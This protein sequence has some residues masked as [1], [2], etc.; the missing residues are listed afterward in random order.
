MFEDGIG[1]RLSAV[2]GGNEPLEVLKISNELSAV[3]AFEPALREQALRLHEFRHEAFARVRGVERLD[4][5][6]STVVVISERVRG[7][8][9]SELLAVVEREGIPVELNAALCL[10]RQLVAAV[11]ALHEAAPDSCHGAIAPER[12]VITPEG[13]LVLVEYV[14][15]PALEE[16]HFSQE[17]YWKELGI[18]LP[19]TFGLP[20]F[21]L[22]ADVTQTGAV[23]LA[24]LLGRRLT[25]D[26]YPARISDVVDQACT[27]DDAGP[28]EPLPVLLR[29]WLRS[30]LQLEPRHSFVSGVGARKDLEVAL[31]QASPETERAAL[32][33]LITK[34]VAVVLAD[35]ANNPAATAAS[36]RPEQPA[37][38]VPLA[39]TLPV[40]S[41][42]ASTAPVELQQ[43]IPAETSAP[44]HLP[45]PPAAVQ[46]VR[47]PVPDAAVRVP[48]TTVPSKAVPSQAVPPTTVPPTAVPAVRPVATPAPGITAPSIP[49][50]TIPTLAEFHAVVRPPAAATSVTPVAHGRANDGATATPWNP[51]GVPATNTE[52][53]LAIEPLLAVPTPPRPVDPPIA[54]ASVPA[55]PRGLAV[56]P[57]T[58]SIVEGA[59]PAER[60]HRVEAPR[61][62][63]ETKERLA[64]GL[65][66]EGAPAK[67]RV[68]N[69]HATEG[70]PSTPWNPEGVPANNTVAP[71]PLWASP[72]VIA[73]A[74]VLVIATLGFTLLRSGRASSPAPTTGTLT[75]GTNPDGIAVFVDG[76][77]RGTTP[78]NVSL[79]AGDHVLELVTQGERRRIPVTLAAGSQ[80]SQYF[81]LARQPA[82]ESGSLQ[83]RSDPP[84]AKVTV[85]GQAY[86]RTPTVVNG[87]MPGPHRVLLE[88]DTDKVS[89]EVV[90][91]AGGTASLVV[92]MGRQPAGTLSG[93][94]A[95]TAPAEVQ[96]F[97]NQR[98][99]GTSRTDR[100]M[101]PVGRHQLE[102]VNEPLGYRSVRGV[103]VTSG[104]VAAVRPDWPRGSVA[105]NALPWAEVFVDGERVGETPIGSALLPIGVHEVVFRHPELGERKASAIVT[106]GAPARLSI[107]MRTK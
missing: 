68:A 6:T 37:P 50:P 66:T 12:L 70:A 77:S 49:T 40:A 86:G 46:P 80:V 48:S 42:G 8:R 71:R 107:D 54:A 74:A 15:G 106:T 1:E 63:A 84:N 85:D 25:A 81:E 26:E 27:R 91:E 53:L 94:I 78:L 96:I 64:Q 72:W 93:W 52:S 36:V 13:K 22:F 99:L 51:A 61:P 90:I 62:I 57:A 103:E 17:R 69:G 55:V 65:A 102:F 30:A 82:S 28:L 92:P 105:L 5:R 4:A 45:E 83:I 16:L 44:I 9:L 23:A 34:Y 73:A 11:A 24:L 33:N 101:L 29:A 21:D 97:E 89:E 87:L 32:R 76:V 38:E 95:V 58:P 14:M 59:P 2:G 39:E 19:H 35:R 3:S 60:P 79:P 10:I 104:Q 98:L 75:V 20:R 41:I 67:D 31:S 56:P 7:V 18:A 100:I 43:E 47:L 88:S